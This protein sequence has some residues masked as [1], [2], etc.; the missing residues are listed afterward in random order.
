MGSGFGW[1][2]GGFPGRSDSAPRH[3][4]LVNQSLTLSHG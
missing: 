1:P 3:H 2:I 4:Q